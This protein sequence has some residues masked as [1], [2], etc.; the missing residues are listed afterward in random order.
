MKKL[1]LIA[2]L[3]AMIGFVAC[4][5]AEDLL[6]VDL[7]GTINQTVTLSYPVQADSVSASETALIALGDNEEFAR[8]GDKIK[9]IE[10][11][12]ITLEID[13][14]TEAQ[15]TSALQGIAAA[16]TASSQ[17]SFPIERVLVEQAD[18]DNVIIA[19]YELTAEEASAL[20]NSLLSSG[21]AAFGFTLDLFDAPMTFDLKLSVTAKATASPLED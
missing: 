21:V 15:A 6:D 19:E 7:E 20:G 13:N 5:K 11:K 4:D 8:Y 3:S 14:V 9:S 17:V 16:G 10:I 1:T 12:K 2:M 18:K